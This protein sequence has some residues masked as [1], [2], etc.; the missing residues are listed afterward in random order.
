MDSYTLNHP[1]YI[2]PQC[3]MSEYTH[4]DIYRTETLR[5]FNKI[6]NLHNILI[7]STDDDCNLTIFILGS[8]MESIIHSDIHINISQWQQL[9]PNYIYTFI[10]EFK[11]KKLRVNVSI[12]IIS[13]DNIFT[14]EKYI[15]PSFVTNNLHYDF[16][17]IQNRQYLYVNE[18]IN[19]TVDIFVCPFPHLETRIDEI[20]RW[21][22]FITTH[23]DLSF[24]INSLEPSDDDKTF[25]ELFY[26]YVEKIAKLKHANLII[27]SF[28][29]SKNIM[30][31]NNYMM[32][33]RLLN[34][35]RSNNIIASEWYFNEQSYL[36]KVLSILPPCVDVLISYYDSEDDYNHYT[37][38]PISK[39]GTLSKFTADHKH[40][41]CFLIK[42]NSKTCKPYLEL[43]MIKYPTIF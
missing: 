2:Y 23:S 17:K 40:Q 9:F 24:S 32:F 12:I 37:Y 4:Y 18:N 35:A 3:L 38:I 43:N 21:N 31:C 25:I 26:T 33:Q 30:D 28:A 16:E 10:E 22:V 27:N 13:P 36:M 34:I 5:L 7:E 19:I 29:V 15:E 14:D 41:F 1:W 11:S 8:V 39:I 42:F 20:T 6:K